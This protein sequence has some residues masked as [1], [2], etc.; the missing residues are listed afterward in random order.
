MEELPDHLLRLEEAAK[1]LG[2]SKKTLWRWVSEGK[3][4]AYRLGERLIFVR[5][6]DL[7]GLMTPYQTKRKVVKNDLHS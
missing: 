1:R 3:L 4:P 6:E 5:E 7:K 2:I